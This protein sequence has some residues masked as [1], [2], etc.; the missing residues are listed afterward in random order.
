MFLWAMQI[1]GKQNRA[2][3]QPFKAYCDL[4]LTGLGTICSNK[5]LN[6][7]IKLGGLG[8][9]MEIDQ[10]KFGSKRKYKRGRYV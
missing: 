10:S 6:A 2:T 1:F 4:A 9:T 8:K 7:G 3:Y 5:V